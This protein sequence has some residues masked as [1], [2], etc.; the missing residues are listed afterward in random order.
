LLRLPAALIVLSLASPAW[1][2]NLGVQVAPL[3]VYDKLGNT[4]S[5]SNRLQGDAPFIQLT[6]FGRSGGMNW[7]QSHF[8][9][10]HELATAA[11][12]DANGNIYV[13]GTRF[14]SA[15]KVFWA[16]KYSSAGDLI[17]EIADVAV[18]CVAVS[19]VAND[20]GESWLGGSCAIQDGYPARL[21]HYGADGGQ[22]WAQNY[23][24]GVRNYVKTMSY[25]YLGR[26]SVSVLVTQGNYVEGPSNVRTVVYDTQGS[27]LTVY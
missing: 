21:L 27:E 15:G 4:I 8:D 13:A 1:A 17:W 12:A 6:S 25:D 5:V 26:L 7:Q 3:L 14:A 18:D 22:I 24:G 9:N 10:Y 23:V 11:A 19:V 16:I 2:A 20:R